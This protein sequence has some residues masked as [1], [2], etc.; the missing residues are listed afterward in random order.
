MAAEANRPP[1]EHASRIGNARPTLN[2][3]LAGVLFIGFGQA[4]PTQI[5]AAKLA[6]S[7][8]LGNGIIPHWPIYFPGEYLVWVIRWWQPWA[9]ALHR[10]LAIYPLVFKTAFTSLFWSVPVSIAVAVTLAILVARTTMHA[11]DTDVYDAGARWFGREQALKQGLDAGGGM[12]IGID[13]ATGDVYRY[14]GNQG[15]M[16]VGPPGDGKTTV[17]TASLL[18]RLQMAGAHLW[19]EMQRRMHPW[20]E[21]PVI[22]ITDPKFEFLGTTAGFRAK[23]LKQRTECVAPLGIPKRGF[24]D[25]LREKLAHYNPLWSARIGQK[26]ST[27]DCLTKAR[28]LIDAQGAQGENSIFATGAES[29]GA[30]VIEHCAFVAINTGNYRLFSIPGVLDYIAS[31]KAETVTENGQ[32]REKPGLEVMLEAMKRYPHDLTGRFG[33]TLQMPDGSM[34][35]SKTKQSIFNGADQMLSL[36][37][38]TRASVFFSFIGKTAIYQGERIRDYIMDS[39]FEFDEMANS[40]TG[41][42]VY[43]GVDA[44]NLK[45]IKSYLRLIQEDAMRVL[46]RGGTPIVDGQSMRPHKRPWVVVQEEAYASGYNDVIDN[47]AGFIRGFGGS[48]WMMWQMWSQFMR[49][50]S[51][52][53]HR[54]VVLETLGVFLFGPA[55]TVDGG[56]YIEDEVGRHTRKIV[57]EQSSG[58]KF[59]LSPLHQMSEVTQTQQAPLITAKEFTQLPKSHCIGIVD[60]FNYYWQKA[61]FFRFR[62][63]DRRSKMKAMLSGLNTVTEPQFVRSYR[64]A[65]GEHHWAE[66]LAARQAYLEELA[67]KRDGEYVELPDDLVDAATSE[68]MGNAAIVG[69]GGSYYEIDANRCSSIIDALS[70]AFR[71]YATQTPSG[72]A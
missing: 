60:G 5:V 40:E 9:V 45:E 55:K 18:S 58:D 2:A 20:G 70:I 3:V 68:G 42:T 50:Y 48:V 12:L 46:T 54:Q 39:T 34:Q 30:A 15:G 16:L 53:G 67:M 14:A 61:Q 27:Q 44:M 13:P 4:V 57:V 64:E 38:R 28:A 8:W 19:T 7:S 71:D 26:D 41:A 51:D 32:K 59:S 56:K 31:F 63:L 69:G 21:E 24:P 65:L 36:A 43:I 35:K 25:E 10:P 1:F 62:E 47:S 22:I 17:I 72:T 37:D 66:F 23:V 29:F 33:W 6:Y 52:P 11:Q 49:T